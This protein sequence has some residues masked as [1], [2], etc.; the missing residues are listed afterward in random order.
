MEGGLTGPFADVLARYRERF[1]AAFAQYRR[2]NPRLDGDAFGRHLQRRVAPLVDRGVTDFGADADG[3]GRAF[4]EVSLELTA[5]GGLG[6]A[7]RFPALARAWEVLLPRM[8]PMVAR[9]PR[10][11][12][13]AVGNAL[14]NLESQDGVRADFWLDRMSA[15]ASEEQDPDRFL[16]LG[17]VVAWRAGMAHYRNRALSLAESIPGRQFAAI[18]G[19]RQGFDDDD[20]RQVVA[21]L[22]Q[23]RWYDPSADPSLRIEPKPRGA[24]AIVAACGGFAGFGGPFHSVPRVRVA[25]DVLVAFD[26]TQLWELHADIFGSVL[27]R[28]HPRPEQR[29]SAGSRDFTIDR[30]GMVRKVNGPREYAY[31]FDE[32]ARSASSA[33]LDDTLAVCL[34]HS[35]YI[36]LVAHPSG[37]DYGPS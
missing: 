16:D 4:Y 36:F 25:D 14:I 10:R 27:A 20:R 32:L 31:I 17:R 30:R 34:P 2:R 1:N 7:P 5:L 18:F 11:M 3:L 26:G 19:L 15:L 28:I 12:L 23:D 22:C 13:D 29:R 37:G 24:L 8:L 33:A 6:S 21:K 35:H 9:Q